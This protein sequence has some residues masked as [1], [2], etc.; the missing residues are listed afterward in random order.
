MKTLSSALFKRSIFNIGAGFDI[1][2]IKR[3][4]HLTD[5][6]IYTNVYLNF[7]DVRNEYFSMIDDQ[8]D[9][10]LLHY[11]SVKGAE[12]IFGDTE[13]QPSIS[14]A[15]VPPFNE[16]RFSRPFNS[17]FL[18]SDFEQRW[19]L[20]FTIRIKSTNR[21]VH[22]YFYYG[23]GLST[24]MYLSR[25][26]QIAPLGLVTIQ[27][28]IL[29]FP[30][31]GFDAFFQGKPTP[32]FWVRGFDADI[33]TLRRYKSIEKQGLFSVV[34]MNFFNQY[35]VGNRYMD[36]T[37]SRHCRAFITPKVEK[38][39]H[40]S[41]PT[42]LSKKDQMI[43]EFWS[44]EMC[45]TS[46]N[47]W[48]IVPKRLLGYKKTERVI[49]W[50][51][52]GSPKVSQL[53]TTIQE[54]GLPKDATLHFIPTCFEDE[55]SLLFAELAKLPFAT[56]TYVPYPLDFLDVK[57]QDINT[58]YEEHTQSTHAYATETTIDNMKE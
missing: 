56:K 42:D 35:R 4:S 30:A 51:S 28:G 11:S 20:Y 55:G 9:F 32:L 16:D 50:E 25:A 31:Q 24:Y 49:T 47:D 53:A 19:L 13:S 39:L 48:S 7:T 41:E 58:L 5:T 52:L 45:H 8:S 22:L 6:F 29:E 1:E 26:G 12:N 38:L 10:E 3:L 37:K 14:D 33:F 21:V 18:M 36:C 27:T 23:E 44:E 46:I 40:I 34:G 43:H 2:I 15:S 17:T 54:F 57:F